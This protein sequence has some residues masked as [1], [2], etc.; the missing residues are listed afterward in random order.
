MMA[1]GRALFARGRGV[2][3]FATAKAAEEQTALPVV[4]ALAIALTAPIVACK[5]GVIDIDRLPENMRQSIPPAVAKY[6]LLPPPPS[7]GAQPPI[8]PTAHSSGAGS[9]IPSVPAAQ[10]VRSFMR[11]N[12]AAICSRL[13]KELADVRAQESWIRTLMRPRTSVKLAH[14]R[15]QLVA[16]LARL[17]VDVY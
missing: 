15:R 16:E 9:A 6:L 13:L 12:H 5:T 17:G 2:R 3:G 14:E 10:D 11:S 1:L 7:A 8:I 4:P